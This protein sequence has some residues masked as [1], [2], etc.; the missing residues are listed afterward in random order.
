[1]SFLLNPL[2]RWYAAKLGKRLGSLGLKYHDVVAE[3]GVYMQAISRLPD[4]MQE[5]RVVSASACSGGGGRSRV[6]ARGRGGEG[7]VLAGEGRPRGSLT[8][9]RPLLQR[10]IK[11]GMDLSSK[12]VGIPEEQQ[13]NPFSEAEVVSKVLSR[14]QFEAD[15]RKALA[16]TFWMPYRL[17]REP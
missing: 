1:M 3:T 11:R 16:K 4:D 7:G 10:R 8:R 12:H 15:E 5:A 6:R 13:E 14:T 2:T 9:A 17:G